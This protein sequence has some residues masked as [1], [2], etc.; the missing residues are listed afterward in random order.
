MHAGTNAASPL[1]NAAFIAFRQR[2]TGGS[3]PR[4]SRGKIDNVFH[5][6]KL[7]IAPGLRISTLLSIFT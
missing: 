7:V 5:K 4:L 3:E 1:S 2:T 6:F